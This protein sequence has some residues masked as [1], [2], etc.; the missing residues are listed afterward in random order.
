MF[1]IVFS[2]VRAVQAKRRFLLVFSSGRPG[3]AILGQR[4][5]NALRLPIIPDVQK[6]LIKCAFVRSVM[7]KLAAFLIEPLFRAR[8]V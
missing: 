3:P 2:P 6:V 1:A 8:S 4:E 5:G 7:A